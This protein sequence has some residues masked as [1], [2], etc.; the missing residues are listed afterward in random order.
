[1]TK[2]RLL[3]TG[4]GLAGEIFGDASALEALRRYSGY[5][6]SRP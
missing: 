5:E 2:L 6:S 1:M 3:E 4:Q